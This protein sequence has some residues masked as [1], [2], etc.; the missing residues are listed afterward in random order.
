MKK[1]PEPRF[2]VSYAGLTRSGL[3]QAAFKAGS[4]G[5]VKPLR[6][7]P[8]IFPAE[9]IKNMDYIAADRAFSRDISEY[10][11][12]LYQQEPS[13]YAG[14]NLL[15][16]IAP[17]GTFSGRGAVSIDQKWIERFP[18]LQGF[19]G[20]T[21]ALYPIGGGAQ[22]VCV[23]QSLYPRLGKALRRMED[24]LG[25]TACA[26]R[27]AEYALKR[28][29]TGEEYDPAQFQLDYVKSLALS[30]PIITQS[31]ITRAMQAV[32]SVMADAPAPKAT[33]S[34]LRLGQSR[35]YQRGRSAA[36]SYA[37]RAVTKDAAKLCQPAFSGSDYISDLW[38]PF[39]QAQEYGDRLTG[40]V[41]ARALCEGWQIAPRYDPDTL[42]GRYP[43]T[44]RVVTVVDRSLKLMVGDALNNPAYGSGSSA[45]GRIN[46]QII[47]P[48]SQGALRL[49]KLKL[50]KTLPMT[51][52][53]VSLRAYQQMAA[54]GL[55]Q[56]KKGRLIDAMTRRETLLGQFAATGEPASKQALSDAAREIKRLEA[57]I[58]SQ[59]GDHTPMS[60]YDADIDYLKRRAQAREDLE[61]FQTDP[62]REESIRGG[63]E[64]RKVPSLRYDEIA[65]PVIQPQDGGEAEKPPETASKPD[66]P[67]KRKAKP[68]EALPP[69][70]AQISMFELTQ[71]KNGSKPHQ[72]ISE[73]E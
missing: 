43:D 11:R 3:M 1:T 20:D 4:D 32:S 14:D 67:K 53:L 27:Y 12:M 13:L 57:E 70:S 23:P 60:G 38:I 72:K 17:N 46:K 52:C 45:D 63:G 29:K 26:Q 8:A 18:Q 10:H 49:G 54:Q 39:S 58:A 33:Q 73:D 62:K 71:Q 48:D 5:A 40:Q 50:E 31:D 56:E 55:L 22:G 15:R 9:L 42:G 2:T 6:G 25:V 68:V 35:Q 51:D 37:W 36:D 66:K 19:E 69:P 34:A 41:S 16:S 7:L 61:P 65:L 24:A 64:V 47:L 44:L 21:L 30:Q 28:L 59:Q